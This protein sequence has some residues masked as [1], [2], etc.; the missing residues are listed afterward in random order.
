MGI[1]LPADMTLASSV[2][3][4]YGYGLFSSINHTKSHKLNISPLVSQLSLRNILKPSG[5]S[6]L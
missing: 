3:I 4:F 5:Q 6:M 1:I 2:L